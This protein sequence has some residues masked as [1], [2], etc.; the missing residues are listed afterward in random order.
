MKRLFVLLSLAFAGQ[1][2]FAQTTAFAPV[3]EATNVHK[4][5]VL[6][7]RKFEVE[8]FSTQLA[9]LRTAYAAQNA[10]ETSTYESAVMT[11]MRQAMEE[12]M[13]KPLPLPTAAQDLRRMEQIFTSFTNYTSFDV[14]TPTVV[15]AKFALLDEFQQ[16][17]QKQYT[18][19]K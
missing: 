11:A 2:A 19:L 9:R 15:T 1:L 7:P 14:A 12:R 17:L 8:R 10:N 13:I 16:L 5:P 4:D 6:G 3:R 18:D